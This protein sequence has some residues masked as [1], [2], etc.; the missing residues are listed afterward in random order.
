MHV[1]ESF[2]IS[3]TELSRFFE[4]CGLADYDSRDIRSDS[5]QNPVSAGSF[6]PRIITVKCNCKYTRLEGGSGFHN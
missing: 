3:F 2:G 5:Y 1:T 4:V 6:H